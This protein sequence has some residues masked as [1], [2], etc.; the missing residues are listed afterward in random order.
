M[1]L[2]ACKRQKNNAEALKQARDNLEIK[3]GERTQ[4][5][6]A[7]NEELTAM[8]E[9]HLALNEELRVNNEEIQN[10]ITE[11]K[12]I[13]TRLHISQNELIQKNNE[14]TIALETVKNTQKHLIQQEKLAGIGQLAAGVAH[15]INNPLG[16]ITN[17]LETLEQYYTA[18]RSILTGYQELGASLAESEDQQLYEKWNQI[19]RLEREQ[20][21]DYILED[22]PELFR[23]TNEGLNRMSKI[24][25]GI[26]TFA[27]IDKERMF[28]PYDLH[29]GLENTLLMA[30]NEIKH[31]ADV[32][33]N[34]GEIPTVEAIGSEINQVLLNIVVNGVQAIK[35]KNEE[36]KGTIKIST[37]R[38]KNFVYCTIEDNGIGISSENLNHIFN[39]FF[40]TKPIGQGTGMG[41]SISCDIIV[42]HHQGEI[43]VESFPNRGT[44]CT[45][46]LPIKHELNPMAKH[47]GI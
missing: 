23:D 3:V 1:L 43:H 24:V 28:A 29:K 21:L 14:L 4:E 27:R 10:E 8:N 36:E 9:E 37:W 41:L 19:L 25:K 40:T 15:E 20:E 45:I 13:E 35:E 30:R 18:F 31:H 12:K 39:P 38:D 7:A 33:E 44:E 32:E 22:L 5:L 34:F 17:N 2:V 11:R 6:F 42:N 26:G 46:K 16:F 47:I